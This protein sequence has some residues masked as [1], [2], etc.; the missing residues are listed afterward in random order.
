MTEHQPHPSNVQGDFYVEDGCCTMCGVPFGEAPELFGV[1]VDYPGVAP[2]T[3]YD[4]CFVKQ[5]PSTP[6]QLDKM[7]SVICCAELA[8]IRYRG[9]DRLIQLRIINEGEGQ[10]C[11]SLPDDL[12]L[13]N[14]QIQQAK[15]K[16]RRSWKRRLLW[17]LQTVWWELRYL[18]LPNR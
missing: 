17:R 10:V 13:M 4:H 3:T 8:C 12:R 6:E 11:D 18:L 7:I 16:E 14:D 5:Q 15:I 9:N 2:G 1:A